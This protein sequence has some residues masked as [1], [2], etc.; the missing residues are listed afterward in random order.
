[1]AVPEV[2]QSFDPGTDPGDPG[3][4]GTFEGDDVGR[5]ARLGEV[6][7]GPP[8]QGREDDLFDCLPPGGDVDVDDLHRPFGWHVDHNALV[9][10]EVVVGPRLE[11]G[12]GSTFG[13]EW[14]G[15]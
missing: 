4:R 5:H 14:A 2:D 9:E 8:L 3:G 6:V 15:E 13:W 7:A 12:G 11:G 1:L 10:V